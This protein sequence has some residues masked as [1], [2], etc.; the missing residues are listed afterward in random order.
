MFRPGLLTAIE[1]LLDSCPSRSNLRSR[2]PANTRRR[3]DGFVVAVGFALICYPRFQVLQTVA[4]VPCL[5]VGVSRLMRRQW[6]WLPAATTAAFVLAFVVSRG[7]VLAVAGDFDG[8]VLFWND[9]PAFNDVVERLHAMPAGTPVYSELW[10]NVLPRAEK[11]PPGRIL[12]ASLAFLYF[13][14]DRAG[15][16]MARARSQPGTV[17]VGYRGSRPDAFSVLP[18][19][20]ATQR[21]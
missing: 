13:P 4:S 15:E 7:A 16:R 20:I 18:Y 17:T 9:E 1:L 14:V 3:R 12:R 8:K 2:N 5:A 19:A 11:L 10:P 21:P 6:H